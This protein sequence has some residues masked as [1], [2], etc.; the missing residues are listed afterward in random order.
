MLDYSKEEIKRDIEAFLINGCSIWSFVPGYMQKAEAFIAEDKADLERLLSQDGDKILFLNYRS[1]IDVKRSVCGKKY[2]DAAKIINKFYAVW[3]DETDEV[4][5]RTVFSKNKQG[6]KRLS[7][8]FIKMG[9]MKGAQGRCIILAPKLKDMVIYYQTNEAKYRYEVETFYHETAH[10]LDERYKLLGSG[11]FVRARY[12]A[13]KFCP[14]LLD[15]KILQKK[16]KSWF[17]YNTYLKEN[18][19]NLYATAVILLKA[20]EPQD[21]EKLKKLIEYNSAV[22]MILRRG[23]GPEKAAYGCFRTMQNLFQQF[24]AMGEERRQ[25]FFI[26]DGKIDWLKLAKF[27]VGVVK[28]RGYTRKEFF[29]YATWNEKEIAKADPSLKT[30]ILADCEAAKN[31]QR[32]FIGQNDLEKRDLLSLWTRLR[33]A[34]D[35]AQVWKLLSPEDENKRQFF[36]DCGF[37]DLYWKHNALPPAKTAMFNH[38]LDG[39]R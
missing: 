17:Q 29:T 5:D 7:A 19:A 22:D 1:I 31:V 9:E 2:F 15:N 14:K 34:K 12:Y 4:L 30:K 25:K 35:K 26:R 11:N 6:E 10:A 27:T 28:N 21:Y 38:K 37:V 18:Y 32:Q 16:I 24:D 20:E 33:Y 39:G 13:N 23:L 3:G 36:A 8:N